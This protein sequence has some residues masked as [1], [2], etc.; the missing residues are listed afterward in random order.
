MVGPVPACLKPAGTK[1]SAV[2]PEWLAEAIQDV[3]VWLALEQKEVDFKSLFPKSDDDRTVVQ[4][5]R[6][7]G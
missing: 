2:T 4:F 7:F 3:K 5:A 1:A 6:S